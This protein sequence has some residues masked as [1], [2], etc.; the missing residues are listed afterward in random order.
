MLP[1][2]CGNYVDYQNFIVTNL[3]TYYPYPDVLAP[4][5]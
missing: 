2:N 4:S 1:I 5:T 3:R